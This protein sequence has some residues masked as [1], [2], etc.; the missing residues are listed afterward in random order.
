MGIPEY[1]W[2]VLFENG[3]QWKC[4]SNKIMFED[5]LEQASARLTKIKVILYGSENP[6]KEFVPEVAYGPTGMKDDGLLLINMLD[7]ASTSSDPLTRGLAEYAIKK[8][9]EEQKAGS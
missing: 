7:R 1:Y 5:A 3:E 6:L 9:M 2:L 8:I 4:E